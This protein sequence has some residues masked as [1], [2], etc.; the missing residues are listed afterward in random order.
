MFR[1]TVTRQRAKRPDAGNLQRKSR[2][3]RP[4]LSLMLLLKIMCTS[5]LVSAHSLSYTLVIYSLVA[6]ETV[7]ITVIMILLF[8]VN[9]IVHTNTY[10]HKTV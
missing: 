9:C 3:S 4:A 8:L 2:D 10:T 7:V 5:L 1:S 6:T